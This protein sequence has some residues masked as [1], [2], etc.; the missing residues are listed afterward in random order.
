M[1]EEPSGWELKR[2]HEQIRQDMREGFANLGQRLDKLVTESAFTAEQ[3]RV[4]DKL[5]DLADDIAAEREARKNGDTGQQ[6]AL[7]RL[8]ATQRWVIAVVLLPTAFF[9]ITTLISLGVF[10]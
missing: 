4:D 8:I 7:D 3:R 2:S 1:A 9:I 10:R 5:K 6:A